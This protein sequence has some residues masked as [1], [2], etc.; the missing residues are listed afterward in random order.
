MDCNLPPNIKLLFL[1]LVLSLSVQ[2]Q[3]KLKL[4]GLVKDEE[5][6]KP[7]NNANIEII[8]G[9]ISLKSTQTGNS[10]NFLF[11]IEPN[12]ELIIRCSKPGY[13]AK[14]ITLSTYNVDDASADGY[15][16]FMDI[17]LFK[18]MPDLDV[19]VLNHPIGA[20]FYSQRE[21]NFDYTVD[22][23]LQKRLEKL[24]E[25]VDQKIK[26]QAKLAKKE[27][28][29]GE[30]RLAKELAERKKAEEKSAKELAE[31]MKAEE[32]MAKEAADRKK[33]APKNPKE[34]PSP[35]S[36]NHKNESQKNERDEEERRKKAELEEEREKIRKATLER[37]EREATAK[38]EAEEQ[39]KTERA[40][41]LKKWKLK[42]DSVTV[43]N[44]RQDTIE[45]VNYIMLRTRVVLNGKNTEF[46]RVAYSWGG[47]YFKHEHLDISDLTYGQ[48]MH[49]VVPEAHEKK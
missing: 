34:E 42:A 16:F 13:V 33:A 44:L 24:Q 14:M 32:K 47:V 22:K 28:R 19:S 20:I 8:N 35:I 6:I 4:D 2:A 31:R 5:T 21:K 46:R 9:G 3:W 39:R 7:I 49:L 30:E 15:R 12:L 45:G 29:E 23:V 17:R 43:Q 10:G 37:K 26:V 27:Q 11:E 18:E 1:F 41:R 48:Y 36:I 38:A 25:E 40:E